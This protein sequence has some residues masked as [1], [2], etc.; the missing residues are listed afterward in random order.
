MDEGLVSGDNR[1]RRELVTE[2]VFDPSE[3]F[4]NTELIFPNGSSADGDVVPKFPH[5][6]DRFLRPCDKG[7]VA[8]E[9]LLFSEGSHERLVFGREV[10]FEVVVRLSA[11]PQ[12]KNLRCSLFQD[13]NE[14]LVLVRDDPV[15]IDEDVCGVRRSHYHECITVH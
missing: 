13:G 3:F 8:K 1:I 11:V 10:E 4:R 5:L 12:S 7:E 15:H 2:M 9:S 14:A 6:C